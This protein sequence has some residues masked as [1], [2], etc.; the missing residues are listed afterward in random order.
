MKNLKAPFSVFALIL[1]AICIYPHAA[2]AQNLAQPIPFDSLVRTGKLPNGMTYY[3]RKNTKPEKRAEL[4]LA[5]NAGAMEENDDQQ[6]LAHFNEHMSFDGT[7]NFEKKEIINFLESS[8]VK[9]GADL[10]AYTSFDETVYKIQI[11]TDSDQLFNKAIMILEDWAHNVADDSM[12]MEME[13]GIVISERRLG[14]GAFQRM[15]EQYWPVLFKDSRYA[16]RLPIGKLD[17]LQNSKR[18]TLRQF[19]LD[20]YRPDLMA[21]A[22]VGDFDV[23]KV[24]KMVKDGFSSIPGNVVER[25]RVDYPVPDNKELLVAEATDKESPYTILQLQYKHAHLTTT[26]LA[27]LRRNFINDLY[28]SMLDDRFNELK[29]QPDPPFLF[30]GV[31]IGGLVRTKDAFQAFGLVKEGGAEKGIEALLTENERARRF[32]FTATELAREKVNMMR[33]VEE[34]LKEKDK[35][36]SRRYV[37]EYVRG[38]LDKEPIPG[39]SFEYKFDKQIVDG[40]TLDEV[41]KV[42]KEWITENGE[43]AVIIIQAPQ[44]DSASLPTPDKIKSIFANVHKMDLKPYVD[45]VSDK[46]L[47]ASASMPTPGKV[48][49]EK[50]IKELGITEWKLSNGVKVVLKP[51]D[52]KNDE[53]MFNSYSWGG[54][55]LYSDKDYMSASN[56][57]GIEDEGGLGEFNSTALEKLLSGKIVQVS[58]HINELT[59]GLDG[60]CS[61]SDLETQFQLI[62][63]YCKNPRKDDT[64]FQAYI[65]KE[66][67]LVENTSADPNTAFSD[68]VSVTMSQYS[69]RRRPATTAIYNEIDENRAFQIYKERFSDAG[70]MT[71]FFVGNFTTDNIKPLVEKYLGSL[72]S[73]NMNPNYKDVGIKP[74]TGLINKTVYRGKEP[75][76]TVE[77]MY[78]GTAQYSR[79]DRLEMQAL[80]SLLSIRLREQLRQVMSGVYGVY[81]GGQLTHF[82][83]QEYRFVVYFGCAPEKVDTLIAATYKVID[84]VKQ[85]GAG[86]QKDVRDINMQKIKE[87]F[88]RQREVDLKDNQFWLNALSQNYQNGENMLE[89][90][91]F[92]KFVDGLTNDDIK[93]LANKYL[94]K[95]NFAKFVLMPE[96]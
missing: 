15:Q 14:L 93:R 82:P 66:K 56:A 7:K 11:P 5:V 28:S 26:T 74:P 90:S 94:T 64:A 88:K 72:P 36:E 89:I 46:P 87:T 47:M 77:M 13:R 10:N 22:I 37:E 25:P 39:I 2:L 3:I 52:F 86:M 12:A 55:S 17:I 43:N 31:G 57:A 1:L 40:I 71:F 84:S 63:L 68:T 75:K 51:T 59:Q 44:K 65:Q 20:W 9:F 62:N 32:G 48:V 73:S 61:P 70:G 42:S 6:G 76:S 45:K 69:F 92:D 79:K 16:T 41:N 83:R 27:D 24:E 38:F 85:F 29:N 58:P 53:V 54:T 21:V 30:S 49:D 19:Y 81:A 35:T 50:Q 33:K 96:K 95:T 23:D 60:K 67:G 4:R 91:D 34:E 80:S 18:S 78:S 8:G